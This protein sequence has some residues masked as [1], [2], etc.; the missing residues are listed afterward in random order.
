MFHFRTRSLTLAAL[1]LACAGSLAAVEVPMEIVPGHF[2]PAAAAIDQA[3]LAGWLQ[4]EKPPPPSRF[5]SC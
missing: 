3:A 2:D 4:S 5:R 1:A